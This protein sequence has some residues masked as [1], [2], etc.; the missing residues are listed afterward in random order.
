MVLMQTQH[1]GMPPEKK[2]STC[3]MAALEAPATHNHRSSGHPTKAPPSCK[4]ELGR[5]ATKQMHDGHLWPCPQ[6]T[7]GR[8]CQIAGPPDDRI[9]IVVNMIVQ[10]NN[11]YTCIFSRASNAFD[12]FSHSI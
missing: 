11:H 9:P 3:D 4:R 8:P 6:N 5:E 10:N 2:P 1:L 7:L 12:C